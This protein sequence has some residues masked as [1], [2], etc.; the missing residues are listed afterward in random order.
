MARARGP[1][2]RALRGGPAALRPRGPRPALR[3]AAH[4][5]RRLERS[6]TASRPWATTCS[7]AARVTARSARLAPGLARLALAARPDRGRVDGRAPH[8]PERHQ[9]LLRVPH[10]ARGEAPGHL[11]A[12]LVLPR[13]R[14]LRG[15]AGRARARPG[16]AR[17]LEEV[18]R[19]Y[20][21]QPA[22]ELGR[23]LA[24]AARPL[25]DPARLLRGHRGGLPHGP[26][27]AALRDAS[28]SCASTASA[29]PR[30][31]ASPPSRSSATTTRARASTR[32][33]SASRSSSRTSCATSRATRPAAGSTC[34]SRTSRA[35]AWRRRTLLAAARGPGAPRP[36]GLPGA[37]RVRGASARARTTRRA[38]RLLPE[39]GPPL[40]ALGRDHGRRSTARCS[41]RWRAA[42]YPVGRPAASALRK[43]RKALDRA[44]HA[45]RAV[46]WG[47]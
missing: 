8:P 38:A 43:P 42:A 36:A 6:S 17:W 5:A 27:D 13:G 9:L 37:A 15:R 34:R 21:G 35:S 25:P 20:A 14:R 12:L 24:E 47:L 19:C 39:R 31:W 3:D 41:R 1:G 29:W 23:E 32:S 33:S 28:R 7:A 10:P 44:A 18:Q 11:R 16:L 4:L 45:C 2:P 22:T 46:R 40:H 30:R 26:H